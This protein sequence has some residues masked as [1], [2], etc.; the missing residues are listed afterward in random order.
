[1]QL[2][3]EHCFPVPNYLSKFY[4]GKCWYE[5]SDKPQPLDLQ[6]VKRYAIFGTCI[7]GPLLTVWYRWL[8]RTVVGKSY[9]II[10]KKVLMDQFLMT[11]HLVW[12]FFIAMS[13]MEGRKDILAECKQ[14]FIPTFKTSCMFWLPAQTVNFTIIPTQFRVVYVGS[15]SLCWVNILCYIKRQQ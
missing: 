15:C 3:M 13:I 14:K 5:T 7:Q 4:P 2:C 11:P 10:L 1:M 8:D 12:L 9:K 6:S